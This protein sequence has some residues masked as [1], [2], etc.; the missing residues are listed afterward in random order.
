ML[1]SEKG[2]LE[3]SLDKEKKLHLV[4]RRELNEKLL[5][6]EELEESKTSLFS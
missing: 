1:D 6:I 3:F 5:Y 4:S 2:D